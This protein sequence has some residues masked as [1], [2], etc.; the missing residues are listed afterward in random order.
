M[1]SKCGDPALLKEG[2]DLRDVLLA[3]A[4]DVETLKICSSRHRALVEWIEAVSE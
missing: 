4:D 2:A 1:M 3:H